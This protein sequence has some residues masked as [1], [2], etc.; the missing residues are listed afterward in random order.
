[1]MTWIPLSLGTVKTY[2][3]SLLSFSSLPPA[4][5]ALQF[6]FQSYRLTLSLQRV[7]PD[8]LE[9]SDLR[10]ALPRVALSPGA[11]IENFCSGLVLNCSVSA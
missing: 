4:L 9:C 6:H 1:M 10:F 2:L 3:D 8:S 11:E 7:F 5:L